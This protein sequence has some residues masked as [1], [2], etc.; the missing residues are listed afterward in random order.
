MRGCCGTCWSPEANRYWDSVT[1][2]PQVPLPAVHA[3]EPT[4]ARASEDFSPMPNQV[5]LDAD[6][7]AALSH[8]ALFS[9]EEP[10]RDARDARGGF[11]KHHGESRS[12]LGAALLMRTCLDPKIA[13]RHEV[14]LAP[15][16]SCISR[17]RWRCS[18]WQSRCLPPAGYD[19]TTTHVWCCIKYWHS[20]KSR[21]ACCHV[22]Q[23]SVF[24]NASKH[25]AA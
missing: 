19:S 18:C 7:G 23:H 15:G 1:G 10:S 13:K 17:G 8:F 11:Y 20:G 5:L 21:A 2:F 4:R 22:R 24:S 3:L 25:N 6:T 14:H 9:E 16:S 12:Q